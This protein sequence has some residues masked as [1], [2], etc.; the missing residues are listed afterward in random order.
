MAH[1]HEAL[2]LQILDM[3]YEDTMADLEDQARR[4]I[5]FLGVPWDDR[6]LD[7][8]H[9]ARVVQTPSR[10]QVRQPIYAR[11]VDRWKVYAAYLPGLDAA[12]AK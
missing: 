6:C 5:D 11:S 10:W 7:F 2:L 12:F 1:W 3:Q 4:L 8:H 9:N